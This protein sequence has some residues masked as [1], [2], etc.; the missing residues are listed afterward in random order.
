MKKYLIFA[1]FSL[2]I[3]FI[4]AKNPVQ[5]IDSIYQNLDSALY[6][7]EA[8]NAV[9]NDI[10]KSVEGNWANSIERFNLERFHIEGFNNEIA[11]LSPLF[12]LNIN[13][14]QNANNELFLCPD[15]ARLKFNIYFFGK[16]LYP[17]YYIFMHNEELEIN[18]NFY[19]TYSRPIAKNARR[20][21]TRIMRKQPKYL[22]VIRQFG[23]NAISYVLNDKIYVFIITEMR[24]YELSD[25]LKKFPVEGW[26]RQPILKDEC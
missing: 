19:P 6:L 24:E 7:A 26:H 3:S 21:F 11:N 4:C 12:V 1:V 14:C 23:M 25:Y 13:V 20:A 18:T 5:M 10:R 9:H 8:I 17:A 22:L 2:S 16:H 15:T